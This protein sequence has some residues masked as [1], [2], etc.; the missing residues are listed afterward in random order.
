MQGNWHYICDKKHRFLALTWMDGPMKLNNVWLPGGRLLAPGCVF[1][2][3]FSATGKA[4]GPPASL[5][6][7][8]G[9]NYA[10]AGSE[11]HLQ[12]DMQQDGRFTVPGKVV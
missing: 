11:E 1:S 7:V 8:H 12:N 3:V 9:E 5:Y 10:A 2:A 6:N 4:L